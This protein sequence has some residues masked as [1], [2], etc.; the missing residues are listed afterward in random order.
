MKVYFAGSIRAGRVDVAV[1]DSM[2][3]YPRFLGEVLTEF[4]SVQDLSAE[5]T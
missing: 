2:I 5:G 1:C 3:S 4:V